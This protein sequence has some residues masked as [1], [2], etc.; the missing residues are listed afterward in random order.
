MDLPPRAVRFHPLVHR[1][2]MTPMIRRSRR[3]AAGAAV[4]L[5]SAAC[6]D[7]G[8]VA[9]PGNGQ[10][11]SFVRTL[12]WAQDSAT[13]PSVIYTD[14]NGS[15]A[16][17]II[18]VARGGRIVR[19]SGR[20]WREM[21]SPVQTQLRSVWAFAPGD[22]FAVGDGGVILRLAGDTWTAMASTT[23]LHLYDVWGSSPTN[24]FAV[25]ERGVI[26][27]YN[28]T[29]WTRIRI[30]IESSLNAVHGTGPTNVVMA[31]GDGLVIRYDGSTWYLNRTGS[32]DFTEIFAADATTT[33][34]AGITTGTV[35]RSTGGG[36]E[37]VAVPG[38]TP[39]E[40]WRDLRG[41]GPNDVWLLGAA[42]Y[43]WDGSAWTRRQL[44]P[45]GV[46][47]YYPLP[48]GKAFA[49]EI[50]IYEDNGAGVLGR[51]FGS[52]GIDYGGVWGLSPT[53]VYA[54]SSEG[55]F[56]YN[57]EQWN[58]IGSAGPVRRI[59][60]SA[61]ENLFAVTTGGGIVRYDGGAWTQSRPNAGGATPAA[62]EG[63]V[64]WS[65]ADAMAVGSIGTILRWNGTSW[66]GMSSGTTQL[67][68]D[69]W[70]PSS[71]DVFAVGYHGT[72][73]RYN[74]TAWSPMT[75]PGPLNHLLAVW[76][77]SSTD[78]FAVGNWGTI[79]HWNGSAW[80]AMP[81]STLAHLY[82]VW[83]HSD[84]DVFAVGSNGSVVHYDGI[85]WTDVSPA[86]LKTLRGVWVANATT[87][88]AVGDSTTI[89]YNR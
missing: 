27:H 39:H 50:G 68:T 6:A 36:F 35:Y 79:L 13:V 45:A 73:L 41:T 70:G 43:H 88:F 64:G 11:T 48:G 30:G 76:G 46:D 23:T 62:I 1:P 60:G 65:A 37:P 9:G 89:L 17:D 47:T 10:V 61:P 32:E 31:G 56:H 75:N 69:V 82:D 19:Y 80:T 86:N 71:S 81:S 24:V 57:G 85:S 83:G 44:T 74:G 51:V 40:Y 12:A 63:I 33:W 22:A 52:P 25:G 15:S 38:A 49:A 26:L 14:M 20:Y 58:R 16:T 67:L 3:L 77:S 4:L 53:S 87:A 8:S 21:T 78:V 2:S 59:W 55:V 28:G 18:A 42:A 34:V 84:T 5:L 72:I 29:Q 54:A 66:Q 7:G